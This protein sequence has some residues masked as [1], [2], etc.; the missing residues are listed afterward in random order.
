MLG[1]APRQG[2]VA[3]GEKLEVAETGTRQAERLLRFH[4][5]ERPLLHLRAAFRALGVA[6]N[7][8]YDGLRSTFELFLESQS[9]TP[10]KLRRYVVRTVTLLDGRISALAELQ[11]HSTSARAAHITS[12]AG[13]ETFLLR[14]AV[15]DRHGGRN[16]VK[17][18][19]NHPLK[20][21]DSPFS[22]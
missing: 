2:H 14:P 4:Q 13:L 8:E 18:P 7:L 12:F 16:L 22:P 9:L 20:E 1:C 19:L 17:I 11:C 10:R 6:Q 21:I 3:R 15:E 5:K